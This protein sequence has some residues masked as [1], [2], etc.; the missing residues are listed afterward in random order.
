MN[1]SSRIPLIVLFGGESAEHDVSCVTA[2]HVIA[3]A[4]TEKYDITTIGISRAG[5]WN[6]VTPTRDELATGRLSTTGT[7]T[8]LQTITS[9]STQCVVLPLLH[10]PLGEDGTVQGML[11]LGNIAY[12]GSGVLSSAVCMD[13]VVSKQILQHHNIE[14]PAFIALRDG[15]CSPADI[16]AAIDQLGYPI[17]VKP[18]NMG[19]SVGVSKVARREDFMTALHLAFQYD[20]W[21]ICEEFIAAREIEIAV[22]GNMDPIASVPGE[23]VPAGEFYDYKDKYVNNSATLHIPALLTAEQSQEVREKALNIYK[24][25]RCDGLA[26]VDFFFEESTSRFLCNE[27]NTIPG[28]TPISMYPKLWEQTGISYSDLIDR[29]IELAF[30]R[31]ARRRRHT[32]H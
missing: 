30:E 18:A 15:E 8:N 31:H 10:G 4:N 7:P 19:S 2:A 6:L 24:A 13:K 5:N 23:I 28:F 32:S 3:A 16:D 11:E 25:L 21:A 26:R 14:Q 1:A 22:L 17:F 27:V 9:L 29:L 20:E 12:V